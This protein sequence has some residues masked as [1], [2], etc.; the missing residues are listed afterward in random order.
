MDLKDMQ[1]HIR[2]IRSYLSSGGGALDVPVSV[3]WH[4]EAIE[5]ALQA[6]REGADYI[7]ISPVFQTPTKTDTAPALGLEGIAEISSLIKKPLIGIGGLNKTNCAEVIRH[8]AHGISIVSAVC[9]AENPEAAARELK[10]IIE[11]AK[12]G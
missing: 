5:D 12:K 11:K 4:V 7:S 9:S 1:Y 2:E 6:D 8:G 10:E 3:Q